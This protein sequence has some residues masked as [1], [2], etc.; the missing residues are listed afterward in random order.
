GI[1]QLHLPGC[2]S[3]RQVTGHKDLRHIAIPGQS[4]AHDAAVALNGHAPEIA[5]TSPKSVAG[6]TPVAEGGVRGTSCGEPCQGGIPVAHATAADTTSNDIA[7]G[8]G[9]HAVEVADHMPPEWPDDFARVAETGFQGT[10]GA[11]IDQ[12][13]ILAGSGPGASAGHQVPVGLQGQ[14]PNLI[15]REGLQPS[16]EVSVANQVEP[17]K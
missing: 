9:G 2:V 4:G 5:A 17:Q 8:I 12:E 13:E 3:S 15:P 7:A 6:I 14:I 11:V 1:C 16:L 10:A